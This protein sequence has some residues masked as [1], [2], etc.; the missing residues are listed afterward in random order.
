MDHNENGK[1]VEDARLLIEDYE[2]HAAEVDEA[3]RVMDEM[4]NDPNPSKTVMVHNN[5]ASEFFDEVTRKGQRKVIQRLRKE[6]RGDKR[7]GYFYATP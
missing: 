2:R 4:E 1:L 5:D 6:G 3:D 7:S